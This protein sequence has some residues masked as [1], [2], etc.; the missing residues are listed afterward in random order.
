MSVN[1]DKNLAYQ[2][3]IKKKQGEDDK[4]AEDKGNLILDNLK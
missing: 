2:R 4:T 1:I 3:Y